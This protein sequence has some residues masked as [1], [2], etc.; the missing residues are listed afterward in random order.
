M[1]YKMRIQP[2]SGLLCITKLMQSNKGC[3]F[4]KTITFN[5]RS[6]FASAL[7]TDQLFAYMTV[8]YVEVSITQTGIVHL[9]H[10][11]VSSDTQ[12]H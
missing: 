2:F 5:F 8:S 12:K 6:T 7:T 11:A 4:T 1:S 10:S 9:C 3:V